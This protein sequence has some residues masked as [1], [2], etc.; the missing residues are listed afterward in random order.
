[1]RNP[2][3]SKPC[4]GTNPGIEIFSDLKKKRKRKRIFSTD[5]DIQK[6]D[7]DKQWCTWQHGF[8]IRQA[9][10]R[11]RKLYRPYQT[12]RPFC[13]ALI[14]LTLENRHRAGHPAAQGGFRSAVVTNRISF[15]TSVFC[16][17]PNDRHSI[18]F[19]PPRFLTELAPLFPR[20]NRPY[21]DPDG[22]TARQY[23]RTSVM[24]LRQSI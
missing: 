24:A 3:P 21:C 18:S 9:L 14:D 17:P 13:G 5:A 8:A 16:F 2:R 22:A 12:S 23:L 15:I 4:L 7:F 11:A 10:G 19:T 1:M 20:A 6:Y